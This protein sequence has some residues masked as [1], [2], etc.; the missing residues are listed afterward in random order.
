MF[1]AISHPV[2][3]LKRISFG[4]ILLQNLKRGSYRHL[5]KDEINHLQQIAKAGMLKA[6]QTRKDT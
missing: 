5:T 3:R 6:N 1:E 2:T 4:D